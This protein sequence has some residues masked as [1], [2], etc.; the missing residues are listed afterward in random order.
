MAKRIYF[1]SIIKKY[2]NGL[3]VTGGTLIGLLFLYLFSMGLITD[4][5]YS[6]D[7]HCTG[8]IENPCYAYINFTAKE[9]IFVYPTGYDPW[10]R[11]STFE[12]E[13]AVKEWKLQRSWGKG[14]RSYDL[15]KPCQY[16]WCGAPYNNMK[17][18]K[19]SLAWREGKTYQN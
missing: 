10:G 7:T 6:G 1:Q 2:A 9:D 4:V 18:N 16:T 8:T 3:T 11:N 19:Y 5:E 13:P 17:N 15:T 14:W 12:F